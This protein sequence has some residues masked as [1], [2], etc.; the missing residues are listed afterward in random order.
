MSAVPRGNPTQRLVRET[1]VAAGGYWRPL[2]AVARLLEELGELSELPAAGGEPPAELA[3]E[4][5][6]LWII[7]TALA[8]QFL[9]EVA[10]PGSA[11][12]SGTAD[13]SAAL[14]EAG[15]VGVSAVLHEA[16][17]VGVSAVLRAAG[18][19]ARV[20]NHYD[21]PKVPRADSPLPSL[22]DAIAA[23]HS[24]LGRLARASGVELGAAVREK[25][26]RI[27]ARGDIERF[28]REGF[29]PS[30]APL[31]DAVGGAVASGHL[32]RRLWAGPD[33]GT[34]SV[35]AE[36]RAAAAR[37]SLE[38]FAKAAPAEG[39]EGFLIAG[40][41]PPALAGAGAW[42]GALVATLDPEG[43]T[44]ALVLGG[45][46]LRARAVSLPGE[47]RVHALFAA[48]G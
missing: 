30:T 48:A 34:G 39:I 16:G 2:A 42:L 19:I 41:E 32:P 22:G 3:G 7:T 13:A 29:D 21:G 17:P 24:T 11:E 36:E 46:G 12:G 6:D 8:D 18:P 10:E 15:Q 47:K 45:A 44:R 4:L 35:S 26:E 40:P 23:F 33:L 27:H 31:L 43:S 5:A 38:M 28:G 14:Q 37:G 1:M 20:V 9:A 25:I